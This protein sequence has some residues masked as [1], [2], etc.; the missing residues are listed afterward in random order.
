[1]MAIIRQATTA[2]R[3]PRRARL[4]GFA[5][6]KAYS[7]SLKSSF[8][9]VSKKK[10]RREKPQTP[11]PKSETPIPTPERKM[12][13]REK[14]TPREERGESTSPLLLSFYL[15]PFFSPFVVLSGRG[16]L[17]VFVSPDLVN[18]TRALFFTLG[19]QCEF[20]FPP[21]EPSISL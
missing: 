17:T 5:L 12:G 11:K 10:G 8:T 9:S 14:W 15:F 19:P 20:F 13:K 7:C 2:T 6:A 18:S 3:A 1:M 16:R 4:G 21:F